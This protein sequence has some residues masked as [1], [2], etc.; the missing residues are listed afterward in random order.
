MHTYYNFNIFAALH[1]ISVFGGVI[2]GFSWGLVQVTC[3]NGKNFWF[4]GVVVVR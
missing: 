1:G 2:G 3:N 4:V